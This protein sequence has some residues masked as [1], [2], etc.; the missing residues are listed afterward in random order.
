M[1]HS[2]TALQNT[3]DQ[4]H[5][6]LRT[7]K[8]YK[9]L[10]LLWVVMLF[11][12]SLPSV[13]WAQPWYGVA[14]RSPEQSI[15]LAPQAGTQ[16]HVVAQS[17]TFVRVQILDVRYY[18]QEDLYG[19]ALSIDQP[20]VVYQLDV[21]IWDV[22]RGVNV[23]GNRVFTN[24][25]ATIDVELTT[26]ALQPGREYLI[27]VTG[28]DHRGMQLELPQGN[29]RDRRETILAEQKIVYM[30]R[31]PEPVEVTIES[32][33]P[34]QDARML[35]IDLA[36]SNPGRVQS[37]EG[38]V[39][40]DTGRRVDAFPP[41]AF[42]NPSI[43]M[44]LPQ[45]MYAAKEAREFTVTIYL[46]TPEGLRSR[47]ATY[48]VKVP[49]LVP[50]TFRQRLSAWWTQATSALEEQPGILIA[51]L[52]ITLNVTGWLLFKDRRNR[53]TSGSLRPP[54]DLP[55][56]LFAPAASQQTTVQ[57]RIQVMQTPA[58]GDYKE[59]L[60][61]RFPCV[62]GRQDA[63]VN[64]PG[65]KRISGLHAEISNRNGKLFLTDLKSRNGTFIN[66]R[67]LPPNKAVPLQENPTV[68]LGTDTKIRLRIQEL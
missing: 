13:V 8:H 67:Q 57:L 24:P 1:K 46:T 53:R 17:P 5:N 12:L 34:D 49:A 6:I 66:G 32:V 14:T 26:E 42:E 9:A 54:V 50:P 7:G 60:I 56:R 30:P 43:K 39:V 15:V 61:T 47:P 31:Q 35:V 52:L 36:V 40:D 63:D 22:Q 44:E 64:F 45:Q 38:F 55:S 4:K 41:T 33:T 62:I 19:L 59:H 18:A 48:S 23:S 68:Q 3:M 11:W 25:R 29:N 16:P 20:Q 10:L 2:L 51:V 58:Q 37:Y 65:D 27:R 28:S 21:F